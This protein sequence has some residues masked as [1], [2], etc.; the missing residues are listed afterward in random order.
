MARSGKRAEAGSALIIALGILAMLAIMATTFITLTRVN[1]RLT[2]VYADDLITEMLA[3]GVEN[4]TLSVLR[5]DQDRTLYKYENRDTPVGGRG[6]WQGMARFVWDGTKWVKVTYAP[7]DPNAI[8]DYRMSI[9]G[10]N[11]DYWAPPEHRYGNAASNDVWYHAASDGYPQMGLYEPS[12]GHYE[13]AQSSF[14]GALF[15]FV[16]VD[17]NDKPILDPADQC[18]PERYYSYSCPQFNGLDDDQDG[19]T[20]PNY[21][22]GRCEDPNCASCAAG[23]FHWYF[24]RAAS[25]EWGFLDDYHYDS[26]D[27]LMQGRSCWLHPGGK[28]TGVFKLPGGLYWRWSAKMGIPEEK[29]INLNAAGNNELLVGTS[30]LSNLDGRG[31]SAYSGDDSTGPNHLGVIAWKGYPGEY[32]YQQGGFNAHYNAVQYSPYQMDPYRLLAVNFCLYPD[33]TGYPDIVIMYGERRIDPARVQVM[34]PEWVRQRWGADSLPADGRDHWRVGWRRDGASYYKIPSPDNPTG[35]DYYFGPG[36]ALNHQNE[37]I[38]PGTS[39]VFE[40]MLGAAGGSLNQARMYFGMA[41]GYLSTYGSDTILRG[42][43]WPEEGPL[44]WRPPGIQPGDWRH[45]D[46]LRKVNL[47]MIGA[48]GPEGLPGEDINLKTQWRGMR[49]RER[50]R[51]Y[52]ML[53]AYL[54][55]T[56]TPLPEHEACQLIASLADMIDRDQ[57]ETY[58]AAP[59]TSGAW[60]LGVERQPVINEAALFLRKNT[61]PPNPQGYDMDLRVEL[62]NPMENI[63]W[64]ADADEAFDISDYVVMIGSHPYR[65]GNLNRFG[66]TPT[67]DKGLV[68]A[69]DV[70][71]RIGADGLYGMPQAVGVTTHP[72]W[73]RYAHLG[74]KSAT[75]TGQFGWPLGLTKLE[76]EGPVTISLWKPLSGN[77]QDGN[78]AV[79]VPISA[80]KVQD[81]TVN[82]LTRRYIRV[83][84]TDNLQLAKPYAVGSWPGGTQTEYIGIYR[85]WDPMN[86]KVYG[87]QGTDETSNVLWCAGWNL[88]NYPTLAS[89]NVNY[90]VNASTTTYAQWNKTSRSPYKYERRFEVN[91]KIPDS[92]LP[93]VGWLGELFLYNCAQ[94]GP[95][96]WVPTRAQRPNPPNNLTRYLTYSNIVETVKLDLFRPWGKPHNLHLYDMFTAWDPMHDGIDNDGDGAIDEA[97]TGSQSG[98]LCG[99][100]VRVYGTIDIN[101]AGVRCI[102]T[103]LTDHRIPPLRTILSSYYGPY[104]ERN[105]ETHKDIDTDSGCM[106]PWDSIGQILLWDDMLTNPG[107]TMGHFKWFD[108][109]S[110]NNPAYCSTANLVGEKGYENWGTGICPG[111][112][113]DGDG[114]TDERDERDLYFTQ[115]AN[116]LT[117]RCHTF[118]VEIVTQLS[119]PPYYPGKN[120][121]RGAYKITSNYGYEYLPYAQR[122]LLLLADR[123]TTL[124]VGPNGSCDFTGPVRVLARRWSHERK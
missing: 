73:S 47:N 4:Y 67:D 40:T 1:N 77:I 98:D 82:A 25:R 34:T 41:R 17:R 35:E 81:I 120:Y 9:G 3:S 8:S 55:F 20:D 36:E 102:G 114:I 60:A 59:D 103:T 37:D 10:R 119:D 14:G 21:Q 104:R 108:A 85:R 16:I 56:N 62:C 121:H 45:M 92:D 54:H 80:G 122:H 79:N 61:N 44:P 101:H 107:Y 96:S 70:N 5:D 113:D 11:V 68:D 31:L 106:G 49:D 76:I 13:W 57:N 72:T 90:P 118:T 91:Y 99:P 46:I 63:P 100:E 86:A 38:V 19:I 39:R 30:R 27:F 84:A 94:D 75:V 32:M 74:W 2:R 6:Q 83:D 66:T 123:S 48:S 117:T 71:R 53:K 22:W 15:D 89:P 109:T 24:P 93:S 97:D 18:R 7:D 58:Y 87:T 110:R 28:L 124:R 116:Y 26:T 42:K 50:D 105:H 78:P 112:D 43:I 95:L 64:I 51:L 23:Q 111:V 115:A 29:Y 65:V 12:E 88:S 52:F 33:Y 69:S